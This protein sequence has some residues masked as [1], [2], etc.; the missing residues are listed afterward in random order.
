MTDTKTTEITDKVEVTPAPPTPV[1]QTE[2]KPVADVKPVA[3]TTEDSRKQA[4]AFIAMRKENRELKNKL[5]SVQGATV[6][7][8]TPATPVEPSQETVTPPTPV[9]AAPAPKVAEVD[10]E[11]ES[12]TALASLASDEKIATNPGAL[13]DIISMVDSDPRLVRLHA[14]D[15]TLAF[16]EA[17]NIWLEKAGIGPAPL[18]PI[19]P[20]VSGGTP[21]GIT[22]LEALYDDLDRATPGTRKWLDIKREIDRKKR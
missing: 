4:L 3:N 8:A 5:T 15:P 12:A 17:K 14:I 18:V 16:R 7:P 9:V 20:N 21:K 13:L 2:A 6:I 11:A 19:A 22:S 10:I 1:T